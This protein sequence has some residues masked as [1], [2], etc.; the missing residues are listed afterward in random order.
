VPARAVR[1]CVTCRRCTEVD[2][3]VHQDLARRVLASLRIGT[4]IAGV[5]A[6]PRAA[7]AQPGEDDGVA[8]ERPRPLEEDGRA[9]VEPAWT[10]AEVEGAPV[11]GQ[12]SGRVDDGE[13]GETT[14]R[15]LGRVLLFVPRALFE[16]GFAPVR[17]VVYVTDRYDLPERFVR[18]FYSEGG[19]FGL[20]PWARYDA[21]LGVTV[22]ARLGWLLPG[23]EHLS[24]FAGTGLRY[25]QMD[26]LLRSRLIADRLLL[27][28]SGEYR[29]RPRAPF[30][31]FGNGDEPEAVFPMDLP[32]DPLR[33][34]TA[35]E[36]RF[37]KRIARAS[38]AADVRLVDGAFARAVTSYSDVGIGAPT[39]GDIAV[40][41]IYATDA[42]VGLDD[43]RVAYTELELRIDRRRPSSGW[44]PRGLLSRGSLAAAFAGWAAISGGARFWR[45]GADLQHFARL[46]RGPQVLAARLYGEAV[47]AP[48]DEIPFAELPR[49]GGSMLLRGYPLER[50]RDRVALVGTIEY[51][52]D[53]SHYVYASL[54]VDIGRVYRDLGEL[55]L[56]GLRCGYGFGIEAHHPRGFGTR[57]SIASSIDGGMFLYLHLDSVFGAPRREER[58]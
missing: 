14:A 16:L 7:G 2:L 44:Q 57:V 46:G 13:R 33:D 4:A 10:A 39:P 31:G 40:A 53:L 32:I 56:D 23:G 15:G 19:T 51:Q 37:R 30:F 38:L 28:A 54:F 20:M 36:A 1:A 41:E 42:L 17:T 22:G 55:G 9:T 26:V 25:Q 6:V 27:G 3:C 18:W 43:Y 58:R 24:A 50:F 48:L 11:P 12:E 45:Y 49:L 35:V 29:L 21:D 47:T 5:L 34:E 52:W 8:I